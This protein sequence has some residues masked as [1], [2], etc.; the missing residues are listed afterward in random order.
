MYKITDWTG[1]E[2]FGEKRFETFDDAEDFLCYNLGDSY[3][4]DRQEYSIDEE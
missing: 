4:D 3:D 1:K 2:V